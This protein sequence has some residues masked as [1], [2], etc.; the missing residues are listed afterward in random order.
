MC[1][2]EAILLRLRAHTHTDPDAREADITARP[3]SPA[4]R[5]R[6]CRIRVAHDDF[7]L[8]GEPAR[9]AVIVAAGRF[10]ANSALAEL[11]RAPGQP[12]NTRHE[13]ETD[14]VGAS[15]K[16]QTR[17]AEECTFGLR[18]FHQSKC[19]E[20]TYTPPLA[21]TADFNWPS[22]GRFGGAVEH[23]WAWRSM[24]L[25]RFVGMRRR[26]ARRRA[27]E[28]RQKPLRPGRAFRRGSA[29]ARLLAPR[30]PEPCLTGSMGG[31]LQSSG[32]E[33]SG[34]PCGSVIGRSCRVCQVENRTRSRNACF[35]GA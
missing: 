21:P 5:V 25:V 14:P 7:E 24:S 4:A 35:W 34:R 20:T 30:R 33:C 12:R 8:R 31:L 26:S 2:Y 6:P 16:A 27:L 10:P 9:A 28:G 18:P 13:S 29:A 3:R 11:A 19:A 1:F 22:I 15:S 23:G 32:P 17:L